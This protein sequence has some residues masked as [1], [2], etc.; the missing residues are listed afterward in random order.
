MFSHNVGWGAKYG[1]KKRNNPN[2][3]IKGHIL[4]K[5]GMLPFTPH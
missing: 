5:T 1:G 3:E 4:K 2:T